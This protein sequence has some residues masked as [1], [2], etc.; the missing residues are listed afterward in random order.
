MDK[1]EAS[2]TAGKN[3]SLKMIVITFA[4][5]GARVDGKVQELNKVGRIRTKGAKVK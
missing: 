4:Q 1:A 3:D 5:N 2:T